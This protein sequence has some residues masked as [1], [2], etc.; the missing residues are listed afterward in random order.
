MN[1]IATGV[2]EQPRVLPTETQELAIGQWYWVKDTRSVDNPGYPRDIDEDELTDEQVD[3]LPP[4]H[5]DEPDEW[6]GCIV[7][8]GTNYAKLESQHHEMRVHFDEFDDLCRAEPD[9][10]MV[11]RGEIQRCREGV[12]QK[13]NEIRELT[14]LL[15]VTPREAIGHDATLSTSRELSVLSQ[16]PD[17]AGYKSQLIAAQKTQLPAL[18]KEVKSL[19]EE[20]AAWMTAETIP[21][22]AEADLLGGV[23]AMIEDRIFSVEV[24]AGLT[25][26]AK[27]VRKGEP[28][29]IGAKLHL[30]QSRLY[31]DEECLLDY[32]HGGIDFKSIGAFDRWLA[33]RKNFTRLLPHD[34]TLVAIRVRRNEK[35]RS[36]DGTLRTA[37]INIDLAKA[38]ETTFLYIRNGEQLWRI[39]SAVDFGD[40][41]FPDHTDYDFTEPHWA[42]MFGSRIDAII[43]DREYQDALSRHNENVR[44]WKEWNEQ[45]AKGK[46]TN[47]SVRMRNPYGWISPNSHF[48]SDRYEPLDT[49][50][51]YYD[52]AT[53]KIADE[54]KSYNRISLLIQGL[55]DRSEVLHPHP[56]VKLWSPESFAASVEL[57]F[58]RDRTLHHG[59][60]HD[61]AGYIAGLNESLGVGS[62]TIGQQAAWHGREREREQGKRDRASWRY[63]A[64][65]RYVSDWWTPYGDG[66]GYIAEITEWKPRSRKA[67]YRWT[68]ERQQPRRWSHESE[69]LP[70]SITVPAA[71]LFNVSAYRPGDYLQFFQ[72]PRTRREYLKWAH[73]L[74]SAEEWHRKQDKK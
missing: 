64:N 20:M 32:R 34:R 15:G 16:A 55:F 13:M 22:K 19:S 7:R 58:D 38:D 14:A 45:H 12:E 35:Q 36:G 1:A 65:E 66:P 59:P 26:S 39:D 29:P 23:T 69:T 56:P 73:L 6:L 10:R 4:S 47:D 18:F 27:L 72:D 54:L 62:M 21:L 30:M 61:I 57:V 37:W 43:H 68:K 48:H 17:V 63:T 25:E 67:T 70:D 2:L 46:D 50:S 41:L 8:L 24:Y 3:A 9:A 28:A 60:P 40:R 71:D 44:L 33:K 31:M 51:V 49:S 52:D 42:R 5:I 53:K 11:I 74:L